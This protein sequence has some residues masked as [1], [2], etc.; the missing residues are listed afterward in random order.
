MPKRLIY[1]QENDLVRLRLLQAD[2]LAHTLT[3]RNQEQIRRWFFYDRLITSEQHK[4]WFDA[5]QAKDDDFVFI[6]ED[7]AS[8]Q[9]V[10][11]VALYHVDWEIQRCEFGRL[12]I[13]E[14]TA[15]GKGL[16]LAATRLALEIAFKDLGLKEVYLEVYGDNLRALAVYQKAGFVFQE[17]RPAEP[18]ADGICH[19]DVWVMSN[20]CGFKLTG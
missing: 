14:A 10:G 15:A 8:Q 3:W 6:I 11:Q 12:M 7:R 5:Y 17:K 2:D 16:A 4:T 20:F 1:P 9:P 18:S 13:G 19:P